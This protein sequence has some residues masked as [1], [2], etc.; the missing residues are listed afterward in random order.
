MTKSLTKGLNE[1]ET[2]EASQTCG[3]SQT[4]P[5]LLPI[6][7]IIIIRCCFNFVQVTSISKSFQTVFTTCP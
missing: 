7:T 4:W 3:L 1:K 6:I 5:Q 2:F